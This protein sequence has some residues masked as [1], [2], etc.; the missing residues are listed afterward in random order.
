MNK[1]HVFAVLVASALSALTLGAV[2]ASAGS[3]NHK[4]DVTL[5][6]VSGTAQQAATDIII[7]NF[8]R[9]NPGIK[10]TAQYLDSNTLKVVLVTQL[11]AGNA[12]DIVRLQAGSQATGVWTLA[13]GNRLIDLSNRPWVKRM[14]PPAKPFYMS[15]GKV[16][17]WPVAVTPYAVLYNTDLFKQLALKIPK[18]QADLLTLCKKITAAGKIPIVQPWGNLTAA[19]IIGPQRAMEYVYAADPKWNEKRA[20]KQVT[21][22]S[23]PLWRRALQSVVDMK[24]AG[25]FQ[26]TP[27]AMTQRPPQYVSFSKGDAVMTIIASS[28]LPSIVALNPN[29]HY[30]M[31]NLPADNAKK[32]I[33]VAGAPIGMGIN[34][35]TTHPNEA[36]KFIDFMAR[37]QQS[38]LYSKVSGDIA[39]LDVK[40][41]LVPAYMKADLGPYF[42][43]G[44]YDTLKTHAW[45]NEAIF[46]DG[47]AAG[48]L[49]L[50]TGQTTV[51]SILAKMDQLWDQG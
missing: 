4:D 49:G 2:G 38:R 44:K 20:K 27:Q 3:G 16:Y 31:F 18:T 13:P 47:L 46:A 39:P 30:A 8:Q 36:K 48:M 40:K 41:G 1:K 11:Q 32:T 34:A 51:D 37:E 22:S 12:P 45:P 15:G 5:R 21:F 28:E 35:S 33:V 50:F 26:P 14:Y 43:A 17:G 9:V 29:L 42:K 19:N 6:L 7:A 23:S 10:V 24:D 25:C